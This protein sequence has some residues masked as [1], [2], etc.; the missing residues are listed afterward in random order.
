MKIAFTSC[1]SRNL[2]RTQPIWD[3][4]LASQPDHVVLLGDNLYLDVPDFSIDQLQKMATWEFTEHL[5]VRYQQQL[6][7]P[8]FRNLVS[9]P[10]ITLHAFWDDNDFTWNDAMGAK[11]LADPNQ[12]EKVKISTNFM[13]AFRQALASKNLRTFPQRPDAPEF[14]Q[15]WNSNA[16]TPL[17]KTSLALEPNGRSWLHLTDRRTFRRKNDLLGTGQRHQLSQ[18]FA[19]HPQALHIIA[20]GVAY[21]QGDCWEN[22]SQ[23]RQWLQGEMI[24]KNWL[25]LSGDL[26]ANYMLIHELSSHSKLVELTASGAAIHAYLNGPI[27]GPEVRNFGTVEIQN[28]QIVCRLL[29][30]NKVSTEQ[31]FARSAGG[32]LIV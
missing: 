28:N 11:L 13:R 15:D 8:R 18:D 23:D 10:N 2:V 14:W 32:Q 31:V 4:I 19:S 24:N 7:E 27:K 22:Y 25:M 26:H 29:S 20:I 3:D 17:G 6:T 21:S 9:A 12:A 1:A 5:F 30:F 16:F